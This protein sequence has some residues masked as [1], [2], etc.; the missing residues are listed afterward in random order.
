MST[1]PARPCLCGA[2]ELEDENLLQNPFV[3]RGVRLHTEENC[4]R[5]RGFSFERSSQRL[6]VSWANPPVAP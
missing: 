3:L 1:L 2:E 4:G 6:I 5:I